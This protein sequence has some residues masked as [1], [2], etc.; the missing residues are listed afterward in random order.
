M[1][2]KIYINCTNEESC[3][4]VF[5]IDSEELIEEYEDV[6]TI[7]PI[8]KELAIVSYGTPIQ[9]ELDD[10]IINQKIKELSLIISHLALKDNKEQD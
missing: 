6:V 1:P 9:P 8:C 3:S 10:T 2:R 4:E 5:L 7:C